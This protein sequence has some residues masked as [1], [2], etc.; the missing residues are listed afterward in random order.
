MIVINYLL[1]MTLFLFSEL[2]CLNVI[3]N[4]FMCAN[5]KKCPKTR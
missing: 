4:I 1:P 2:G 5:I 3:H